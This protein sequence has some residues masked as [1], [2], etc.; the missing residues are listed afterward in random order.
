MEIIKIN[1]TS[2][3]SKDLLNIIDE[4]VK[5]TRE[6]TKQI[7]KL[8]E[9]STRE[10]T[11]VSLN[12]PTL[13][14]EEEPNKEDEDFEQAVSFFFK[15]I[16][17]LDETSADFLAEN[18]PDQDDYDYEKILLRL[19]AELL[20]KNI[21]LL[22]FIKE[23]NLSFEDKL[24]FEAE[25]SKNNEKMST[26]G[27]L[28]LKKEEEAEQ[29]EEKVQNKLIFVPSASGT[30]IV[31]NEL[32]RID[33]AYYEGFLG[34]FDSIRNGSFKNFSRLTSSV[35]SFGGIFEVKDFKIR[36][37]FARLGPT[38]YAVISAFIKKVQISKGYSELLNLRSNDYHRVE[39]NFKVNLANEEFL[40]LH[41]D[42][43]Q[44]LDRLLGRTTEKTK[45]KEKKGD[46]ND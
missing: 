43:E 28:M 2:K 24:A 14:Q 17:L 35:T 26:I 32:K 20:R 12:E 42:Y 23:E 16:D 6:M 41:A 21:E 3:N 40:K 29:K 9:E 19:R 1:P 5:I 31:L 33:P 44:E 13:S 15:K 7:K 11:I 39:Q 4:N 30:P 45:V 36:V 25:L 22:R 38:E 37:L 10:T 27:N 34:L 18:L 8:Q 46:Q